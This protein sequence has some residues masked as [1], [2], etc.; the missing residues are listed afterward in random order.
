MMSDFELKAREIR[1]A[2]EE[3]LDDRKGMHWGDLDEKVLSDLRRDV[4]ELVEAVLREDTS[5]LD[6]Y[7][8]NVLERSRRIS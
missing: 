7:S 1:R 8:Q 3:L 6:S 2:I 4:E 5:E